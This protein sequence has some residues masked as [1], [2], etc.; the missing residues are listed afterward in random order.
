MLTG[1]TKWDDSHFL[2]ELF[3]IV[4]TDRTAVTIPWLVYCRNADKL[5]VQ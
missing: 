2:S 1:L 3:G 4:T 5:G